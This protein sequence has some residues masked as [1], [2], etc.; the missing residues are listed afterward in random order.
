MLHACKGC[1]AQGLR[2]LWK[3]V[4]PHGMGHPPLGLSSSTLITQSR[5]AA[6][7]YS[8]LRPAFKDA[9][10]ILPSYWAATFIGLMIFI[11]TLQLFW[12]YK[13]VKIAMRGDKSEAKED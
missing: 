13:I 8:I 1:W 9:V 5:V 11:C 10:H 12:F 7:P 3:T 6:A 2:G 4:R